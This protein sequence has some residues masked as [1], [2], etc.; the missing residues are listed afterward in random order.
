MKRFLLILTAISV[1]MSCGNSSSRRF[2]YDSGSENSITADDEEQMYT[3]P[4][5]GGTGVFEYMPGDVMAPREVCQGCGGNKVVTA[6]QAEAIMQAKEQ[7]E[8][9]M[10]GGTVGGNYNS[11]GRSAY[12]IEMEL[13]EAYELLEDMEYNYENCTGTVTASQYPIM[14]ATQKL[15]ISQLEAELM[16]AR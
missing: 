7:A 16:N 4:M 2:Q 10:N 9:V 1:F 6:E 12:E 8:A 15:R 14:I 3:C 11:E 5:C 13:K